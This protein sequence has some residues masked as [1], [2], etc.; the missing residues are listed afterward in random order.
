LLAAILDVAAFLMLLSFSM[1]SLTAVALLTS[2][3]FKQAAMLERLAE[4]IWNIAHTQRCQWSNIFSHF[5]CCYCCRCCCC[6]RSEQHLLSIK[7][8]HFSMLGSSANLNGETKRWSANEMRCDVMWC[9]SSR[10]SY[11]YIYSCC[12]NC[13]SNCCLAFLCS[14][15]F[16]YA[17][18]IWFLLWFISKVP[19]NQNKA[20][21][22]KMQ[23][24]IIF[25]NLTSSEL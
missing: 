9:E 10:S 6:L 17:F 23:S 3:I 16:I 5:C 14:C 18:E 2:T 25:V 8:K 19:N 24:C 20:N 21:E 12:C 4:A 13:L 1:L 7:L 22:Q 11:S 15:N